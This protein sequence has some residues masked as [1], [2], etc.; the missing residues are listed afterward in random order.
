MVKCCSACGAEVTEEAKRCAGCGKSLPVERVPAAEERPAPGPSQSPQASARPVFQLTDEKNRFAPDALEEQLWHGQP[1]PAAM[2]GPWG[3]SALVVI[4]V[5]ITGFTLM[6]TEPASFTTLLSVMLLGTGS[7]ICLR[8]RQLTIHYVLTDR[9]LVRYR[10]RPWR[11]ADRLQVLPLDGIRTVRASKCGF[12]SHVTGRVIR[13]VP[14]DSRRRHLV[15]RSV[16]N[17]DGLVESIN[18]ARERLAQQS[19]SAD[20]ASEV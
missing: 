15:L 18:A 13:A 14:R 8:Y 1:E 7:L 5:S 10:A 12:L 11:A 20:G 9:H 2:P 16:T 4:A 3:L 19:S 6:P 17:I